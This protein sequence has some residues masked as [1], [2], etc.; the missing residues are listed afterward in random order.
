MNFVAFRALWDSI[1]LTPK[2]YERNRAL[3]DGFVRRSGKSLEAI[4]R[5]LALYK[6]E[7]KNGKN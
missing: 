4:E 3:I 6:L 5:C 7:A 2:A 1:P